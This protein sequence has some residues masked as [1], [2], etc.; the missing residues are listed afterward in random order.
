MFS[1][2]CVTFSELCIVSIPDDAICLLKVSVKTDHVFVRLSFARLC[3]FIT[4][5]VGFV[6]GLA[7]DNSHSTCNPALSVPSAWAASRSLSPQWKLPSE[8]SKAR[9]PTEVCKRSSQVKVSK[10]KI[11]AKSWVKLRQA[12]SESLIFTIWD[13]QA[14]EIM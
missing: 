1:S 6:L 9:L 3:V 10:R 12:N 11:Q 2:R 14:Q 7:D 4:F 13:R 5:A 8:G